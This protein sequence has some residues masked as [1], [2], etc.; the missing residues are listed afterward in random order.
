MRPQRHPLPH[1]RHH[2]GIRNRQQR[3]I[4]RETHIARVQEDN[5]LIRERA[6]ARVDAGDNVADAAEELVLFG[7]LQSDLDEDDLAAEVG[8]L[9][10]EGFKG[11][12]FVAHALWMK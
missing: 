11:E 4:L 10:E 2:K 6:E 9:V 3:K 7:G 5:G 12:E 8:V 1:T